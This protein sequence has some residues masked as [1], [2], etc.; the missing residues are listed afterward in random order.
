MHKLINKS[1]VLGGLLGCLCAVGVRGG[2][3]NV[4]PTSE[5]KCATGTDVVRVHTTSS[6]TT[7]L[8]IR[9]ISVFSLDQSRGHL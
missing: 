8:L 9:P 6:H 3:E 1:I 4:L 2:M 5:P 7:G